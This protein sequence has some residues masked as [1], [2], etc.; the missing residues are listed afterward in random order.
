MHHHG[1]G[2]AGLPVEDY[3]EENLKEQ[4]VSQCCDPHVPYRA[5][6]MVSELRARRRVLENR[7][8]DTQTSLDIVKELLRVLEG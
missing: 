8:Q 3:M 7:I 2:L 4:V 1:T 6:Q 5:P